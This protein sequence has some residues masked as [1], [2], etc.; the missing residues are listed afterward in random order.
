MQEIAMI[1]PCETRSSM[2]KIA[3]MD[4][5]YSCC[6]D[7]GRKLTELKMSGDH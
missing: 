4:C 3:E 1:G 7:K 2:L 5:N 6:V